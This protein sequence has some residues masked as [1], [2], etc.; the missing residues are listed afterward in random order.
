MHHTEIQ[1][2]VANG[3]LPHVELM[4]SVKDLFISWLLHEPIL[5]TFAAKTCDSTSFKNHEFG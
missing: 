3:L 1:T 4:V 5:H 2:T